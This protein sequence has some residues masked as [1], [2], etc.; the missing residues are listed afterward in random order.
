MAVRRSKTCVF[1]GDKNNHFVL[2]AAIISSDI[3]LTA[4]KPWVFL[5]EGRGILT[6]KIG[7]TGLVFGMRSGT[8]FI[9]GSVD[10]RLQVTVC[11]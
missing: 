11:D 8:G 4:S 6:S 7:Q 10:A 9:S 3:L 1:H 2:M 5:F